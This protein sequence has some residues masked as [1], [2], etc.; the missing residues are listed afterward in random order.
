[1]RGG[2]FDWR[3]PE[4][5]HRSIRG[6]SVCAPSERSPNKNRIFRLSC[7]WALG[8]IKVGMLFEK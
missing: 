3:S 1:V 5:Q 8:R 7:A 6:Y 4:Y 2:H